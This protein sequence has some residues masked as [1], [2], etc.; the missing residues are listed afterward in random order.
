MLPLHKDF[1]VAFNPLQA[2]HYGNCI[3][4]R[5]SSMVGTTISH[6]KVIEKIGQWGMGEVVLAQDPTAR[7]RLLLGRVM[8]NKETKKGAQK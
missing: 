1:P 7:T 8:N 5:G 3:A 2:Y 6:Y 4:E